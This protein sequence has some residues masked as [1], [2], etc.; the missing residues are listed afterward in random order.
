[1][2]ISVE[3]RGVDVVMG[4]LARI[5]GVFQLAAPAIGEEI[6]LRLMRYPPPPKYPLRWASA[7]QA[8]YVKH[9]LRKGLGPYVRRFDQMSQDLM[10]SWV[11]DTQ[12]LP[13][14][15]VVGTRVSYAPYV[16]SA[17]KQQPFH[18]DTGWITDRQ[19]VQDVQQAGIVDDIVQRILDRA[20][21]S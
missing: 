9:V 3:V 10:H 7:K 14:E 12:R 20:L 15:V 1:M 8:F 2:S 21:R 16:Q 13:H 18:A 5:P 4:A 11:V 19:A 6:R 17:E